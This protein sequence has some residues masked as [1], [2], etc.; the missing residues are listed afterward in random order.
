MGTIAGRVWRSSQFGAQAPLLSRSSKRCHRGGDG[1][2]T[3]ALPPGSWRLAA[4][5]GTGERAFTAAGGEPGE[6]VGVTSKDTGG[7]EESLERVVDYKRTQRVCRAAFD[8][9]DG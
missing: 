7:R 1:P 4:F 2:T 3:T 8:R 6:A 5:G 9:L